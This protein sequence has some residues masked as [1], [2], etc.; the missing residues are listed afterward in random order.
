LKSRRCCSHSFASLFLFTG[1]QTEIGLIN[2][3][4]LW[5]V[6]AAIIAVAVIGK[7]LGSLGYLRFVRQN[8]K[9]V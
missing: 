8:W 6:T 1:L 4:Y 5:K 7:F 3:S 2:D 9:I